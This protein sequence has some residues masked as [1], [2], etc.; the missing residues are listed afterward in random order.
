MFLN[1]DLNNRSKGVEV[2]KP[3]KW[4]CPFCHRATTINER[5]FQEGDVVLSIDNKHGY[6]KLI[7]RFI[8]CPNPECNEFALYV[9]LHETEYFAPHG[10]LTND[11][12][13]TWS[14]I[15][16]FKVKTLPNYIPKPI[17][18]DYYEAC[19]IRELSPKA[20]ATLSRRCLQGMI[21]DFWGISQSRLI[22]EIEAIKE[23]V[24]PLTWE[25]IDS[26]RK[27]G[28]IGAH[29]EKDINIVID[30]EP[31]ESNLLIELIETLINDWYVTRYERQKRLENIILVAEKKLEA[32]KL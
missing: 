24:D 11:H 26:I 30:V 22:D 16:Q 19:A 20:S 7:V 9:D 4:T 13:K 6:R 25:A 29:M 17:I 5:D 12:I 21:R 28:N 31:Q 2:M 15:P 32:K 23:K 10:W 3:F 18:D 27:I 1:E 14:L 8:V